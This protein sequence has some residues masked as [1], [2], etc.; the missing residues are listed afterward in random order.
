MLINFLVSFQIKE[1]FL[2][3]SIKLT[4]WALATENKVSV[5]IFKNYMPS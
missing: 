4:W 2:F 5:A 3:K 1:L